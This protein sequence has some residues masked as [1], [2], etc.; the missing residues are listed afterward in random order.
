[1]LGKSEIMM[2]AY[3]QQPVDSKYDWFRR[4][5]CLGDLSKEGNSIESLVGRERERETERE[6]EMQ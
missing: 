4:Q 3:M 6:R 2:Y 1:M 5:G